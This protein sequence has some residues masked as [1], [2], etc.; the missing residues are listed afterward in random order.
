MAVDITNYIANPEFQGDNWRTAGGQTFSGGTLN[1]VGGTRYWYFSVSGSGDITYTYTRVKLSGIKLPPTSSNRTWTFSFAGPSTDGPEIPPDVMRV[2]RNGSTSNPTTINGANYDS[3]TRRWYFTFTQSAGTTSVDLEFEIFYTGGYGIRNCRMAKFRLAPGTTKTYVNGTTAGHTWAG[4]P[5]ASLTIQASLD[6]P[7]PINVWNF[8][9]SPHPSGT[10]WYASSPNATVTNNTQSV[11]GSLYCGTA[12]TIRSILSPILDVTGL[13]TNTTALLSLDITGI[14]Y[15]AGTAADYHTF[16][17][18]IEQYNASGQWLLSN[19]FSI[20]RSITR[21]A[22]AFP[23]TPTTARIE[24]VLRAAGRG[25]ARWLNFT[26]DNIRLDVRSDPTYIGG[27]TPGYMWSGQPNAST[28]VLGVRNLQ[29]SGGITFGGTGQTLIVNTLQAAGAI[30]FSGSAQPDIYGVLKSSGHL[31][32]AGSARAVRN[33]NAHADGA[34]T[35]GGQALLAAIIDVEASGSITLGGPTSTAELVIAY[36][37]TATGS[38]SFDGT[39]EL[40]HVPIIEASASGQMIFDGTASLDIGLQLSASGQITFGGVADLQDA[41]PRGAFADFAIYGVSASDTD[42]LMLGRG[43]T[44]AG[45]T[46]G[47]AGQPWAR[48]WGEFYAPAELANAAGEVIFPRAAYAAIGIRFNGVAPGSWQE[49]AQVQVE[50]TPDPDNPGPSDYIRPQLVRPIVI[51]DKINYVGPVKGWMGVWFP[52]GNITQADDEAPSPVAEDTWPVQTFTATAPSTSMIAGWVDMPPPE[53]PAVFSVYIRLGD[54]LRD[55]MVQVCDPDWNTLAYRMVTE[56]IP[57]SAGWRRVAVSYTQP[58]TRVFVVITP[59]PVEPRTFPEEIS[60][61]AAQLEQGTE[62]TPYMQLRP[63]SR[64]D[65]YWHMETNP[66]KGQFRYLRIDE[67]I[68]LLVQ[69]L[70][71]FAPNDVTVGEPEFG[72]HPHLE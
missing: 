57:D 17:L 63:G 34:I 41:I 58:D 61:A 51:P 29:G 68:P 64:E 20:N 56:F 22:F 67:R 36:P 52:D 27:D 12:N 53:G 40:H 44:N 35:F 1:T 21:Q 3:Y 33:G 38:I 72:I 9:R 7:S 60:L 39:A 30:S 43:P 42:P 70:E 54:S 19:S 8:W 5:H 59:V 23:V 31:T 24:L 46:T 49:I 6:Q 71:E 25:S 37:A 65:F 48:V 4:T 32:F 47:A 62:P 10:G 18:G 50:I 13:Q 11:T 2:Y 66:T 55:A 28:T 14:T 69:A 45:I 15:S 26:V 16:E